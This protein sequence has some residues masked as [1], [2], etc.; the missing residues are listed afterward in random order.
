MMP[1][2]VEGAEYVPAAAMGS[3]V[4]SS[5]GAD[6]PAEAQGIRPTFLL[7]LLLLRRRGQD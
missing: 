2:E 3:G 1:S 7:P 5:G 4:I 6:G